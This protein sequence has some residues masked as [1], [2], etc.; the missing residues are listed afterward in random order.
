MSRDLIQTALGEE[1][2]AAYVKLL[3]AADSL[4]AQVTKGL[5]PHNLTASQFSAMKVL[6]LRGP[7]AQRDIAKYLVMASGNVTVVIDNLEK[8]KLVRRTRDTSDRRIVFVSLTEAGEK[9]F[10]EIYPS[11]LERIREVMSVLGGSEIGQLTD[12]LLTIDPREYEPLCLTDAEVERL[13]TSGSIRT[14]V[15]QKA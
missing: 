14:A 7:L 13:E 15:S 6:R 2:V 4:R 1:P 12:L 11:H 5:T 10:D 3:R 8:R 9:V